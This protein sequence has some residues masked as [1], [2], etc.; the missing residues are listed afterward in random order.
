MDPL[1]LPTHSTDLASSSLPM[2][3][4]LILNRNPLN[5][6]VTHYA[7][8]TFS[9]PSGEIAIQPVI[10]RVT[11]S[12]SGVIDAIICETRN[13]LKQLYTH[14]GGRVRFGAGRTVIITGQS[15]L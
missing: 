2:T 11:N 3:E 4:S 15:Q 12:M 5:M 8:V 13:G 6:Q 1:S 9:G 14:D 10:G 7:K